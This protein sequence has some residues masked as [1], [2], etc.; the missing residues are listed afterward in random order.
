MIDVPAMRLICFLPVLFKCV[1][2]V[3][4]ELV[5]NNTLD[6]HRVEVETWVCMDVDAYQTKQKSRPSF[7]KPKYAAPVQAPNSIV[8]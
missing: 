4:S 6:I 7:W 3:C 5:L 8:P 2:D 1:F